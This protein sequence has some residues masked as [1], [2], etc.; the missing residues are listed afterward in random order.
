MKRITRVAIV[1]I[2]A[3][4]ACDIL[5]G[6]K[7]RAE[8][9]QAP[10]FDCVRSVIAS[11]PGIERVEYRAWEG[12]RPLTLSGLERADRIHT[13]VYRGD[14]VSGAVQFVI[15]YKG[16]V[17]FSDTLLLLHEKPSQTDIDRTRPVMQ[18]IEA[19]LEARCNLGGLVSSIR[20]FCRGVECP[21][22]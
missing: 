18:A 11:T 5:Y 4:C 8:L 21:E 9:A 15:D 3:L 20:E 6:V 17:R 13:F 12:S 1:G 19:G 10:S 7:R 2:T 14:G 22:L 16:E